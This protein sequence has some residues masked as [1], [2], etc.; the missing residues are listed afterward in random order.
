[1]FEP[2]RPHLPPRAHR[3]VE[4]VLGALPIRVHVVRP[5][6]TKHGD[7]RLSPCGRFHLITVNAGGNAYQFLLTLLHE[8]AH[9]MTIRRH[10]RRA[11]AHGREWKAIFGQLL[12][13]FV[14]LEAFPQELNEPVAAHARRP[15]FSSSADPALQRVLRI[16]DVGD[17]RPTVEELARGNASRWTEGRR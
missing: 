9:A 12:R 6:Q 4:T 7:H 15:T 14:A 17:L 13:D 5:R 10:G 11:P 16:Y 2:L 8:I 3:A 1:M